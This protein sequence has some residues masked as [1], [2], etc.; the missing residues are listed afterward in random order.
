[1]KI[2]QTLTTV[3]VIISLA[4]ACSPNT[5]TPVSIDEMSNVAIQLTT[6]PNN[7]NQ[8]IQDGPV[9]IKIQGFAFSPDNITVKVGTP[10]TWTNLDNVGHTATALDK[11]YD[12]GLLNNGESFTFQFDQPGTFEYL[13]TPHPSMRG[14]ITVVP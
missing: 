6:V 8:Q 3:M 14:T 2:I 13:C 5:T 7:G 4:A 12:S 10:V 1:M 9:S 11:S